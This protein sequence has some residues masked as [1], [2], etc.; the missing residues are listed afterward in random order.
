MRVCV[1]WWDGGDGGD[2]AVCLVVVCM[3]LEGFCRVVVVVVEIG[4]AHV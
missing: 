2:M 3:V 4:R 1:W